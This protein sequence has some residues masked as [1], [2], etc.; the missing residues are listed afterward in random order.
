MARL[1]WNASYGLDL[2]DFN[3]S[4]LYYGTSYTSKSTV[5]AVNYSYLSF[6]DE[7]R[8]YGF[9]YDAKGVPNG[10]T[11]TS[12]AGFLSGKKL[13][14]IDGMNIPIVKFAKAAGTAS[15]SDDFGIYKL[16]LAGNDTIAGGKA[17]D[18]IEGFGGDDKLAGGIGADRLYGGTGADTFIFKSVRDS[19]VDKTGRDTIFDFSAKQKDKIDLSGIDANIMRAGN[20]AFTFIAKQDF[21]NKPG[22]LRYETVK[23]YTYIYGDVNGDGQADFSIQLKGAISLAKSYFIL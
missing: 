20:Q 11:V 13:G 6:R 5:F 2:R 23:G 12:Y 16:A 1:I 22:E 14:S 3:L 19:A 21:H 8:G 10:G 7:F 18:R 15:R 9:T 17:G 4:S